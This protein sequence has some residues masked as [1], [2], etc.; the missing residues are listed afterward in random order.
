MAQLARLLKSPS[1]RKRYT[2]NYSSWLA[3]SE[4]ITSKEFNVTPVSATN[5]LIVSTS[6]ISADGKSIVF[7]VA[8]GVDTE[9]YKIEV[10][11]NTSDSQIKEDTVS[12]Y[13][14]EQ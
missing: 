10:F 1:E 9:V 3:A 12:V 7:Y 8:G 4:T 5:P 6:A 2:L 11:I 14:K 13:V